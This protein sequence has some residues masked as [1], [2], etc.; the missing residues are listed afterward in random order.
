MERLPQVSVPTDLQ[1]RSEK[2][3]LRTALDDRLS[4]SDAAILAGDLIG[5]FPSTKNIT[6]GFIGALANIFLQ[7][8]KQVVLKCVDPLHGLAVDVKFL[9]ISD[10]VAWCEKKT[11]PMRESYDRQERVK[12]QTKETEDWLDR[13]PSERLKAMGRAWLDRTDPVARQLAGLDSGVKRPTP[14]EYL[15]DAKKVGA[16]ISGMS[17][18]Q[19]ARERIDVSGEPG[20]VGEGD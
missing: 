14:E 4:F 17:L 9:N 15:A 11:A 2:S 5:L 16:E 18:S 6:D 10:L 7:Y 3:S 8:P 12:K 1:T 20:S 13:K 19:E